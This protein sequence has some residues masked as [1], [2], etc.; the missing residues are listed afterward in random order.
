MCDYIF[1]QESNFFF[2]ISPFFQLNNESS[3]WGYDFSNLEFPQ[4]EANLING[5][6]GLNEEMEILEKIHEHEQNEIEIEKKEDFPNFNIIQTLNQQSLPIPQPEEKKDMEKKLQNVKEQ[7]IAQKSTGDNTNNSKINI[8]K[9]IFGLQSEKKIEPRIDYAIKNIKVYISKYIKNYGN[10]LIKECKFQ[11]KLQKIKLFSPSYDY[12]T[13]NSNEKDN[14][15]YLDFTVEQIL[16]YPDKKNK[17]KK[18]DRLQRQNQENIKALKDYIEDNYEENVPEKMQELLN[19]FRMT[20]EE[21]VTLF[22]KSNKF[23]DYSSS[24]KTRKLDELFIKTKGF[25]LMENNGFIKLM[26]NYN[27]KNF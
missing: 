25:S 14:N 17:K 24:E 26:K 15:V 8:N 20:Y 12:F 23:T 6:N 4:S 19:F 2:N 22:Y 1:N 18:G 9:L 10:D 5:E 27:K 16:T 7:E 13:G 21:I 11:N 3:A